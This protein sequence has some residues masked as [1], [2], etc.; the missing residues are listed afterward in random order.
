MCYLAV[1]DEI[2]FLCHCPKYSDVR[3]TLFNAA[4]LKCDRFMSINVLDQFV[5]LM[6]NL[7]K[8]VINFLANAMQQRTHCL[9]NR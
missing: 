3:A 1:E 6:S 8:E 5:F 9:T 7:Q 2:H 4:R